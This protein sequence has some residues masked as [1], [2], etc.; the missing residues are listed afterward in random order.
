LR[1]INVHALS[2]S[3]DRALTGIVA[4]LRNTNT[5][6]GSLAKLLHWLGALMILVLL[7]HGWWMTHMTPRAD[8]F[9]NYT[10]HAAIGYDLLA[11]VVLR[12]LWRWMNPVPTLPADLKPWERWAA[13]LG[14]FGLYLL[15]LA[16]SLSGW[17]LAGTF[18]APMNKDL[19]GMYVPLIVKSSDRSVHGF[20]EEWH[21]IT[22]YLL[23]ALVVIHIIGA[24][25]HQ[26]IKHN[27]LLQRMTWGTR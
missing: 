13:Y 1:N 18:K 2:R 21:E 3:F 14:H 23:A 6:W 26:F 11:L 27:D 12:I 25:R 16:V 5:Q 20:Y 7:I 8:R 4:M 22:A 19:F 9:A 17:A 24:L 15:M 10:L